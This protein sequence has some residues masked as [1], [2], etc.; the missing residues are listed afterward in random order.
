MDTHKKPANAGFL[1]EGEVSGEGTQRKKKSPFFK[2]GSY[3]PE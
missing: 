3:Q 1:F 2:G